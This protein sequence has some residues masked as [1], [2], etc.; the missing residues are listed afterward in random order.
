[1]ENPPIA[2]EGCLRTLAT[3]P[4]YT[5]RLSIALLEQQAL[6][7]LLLGREA[8]P[9]VGARAF[10]PTHLRRALIAHTAVMGRI[11]EVP[12]L[13]RSVSKQLITS[14]SSLTDCIAS[15]P[16]TK[17]DPVAA[18]IVLLPVLS[19]LFAVER[20]VLG[21]AS[22]R[23]DVEALD[24][25]GSNAEANFEDFCGHGELAAERRDW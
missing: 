22:Y 10:S 2:S 19:S 11:A 15:I 4:L 20:A 12:A 3:F 13:P 7:L 5:S 23:L 17:Q 24:H 14:I 16:S 8:T 6:L 21:A 9:A 25:L 1:M 18:R